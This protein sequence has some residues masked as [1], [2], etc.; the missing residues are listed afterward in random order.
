MVA[1]K[2]WGGRRGARILKWR[3]RYRG[4][5]M[6]GPIREPRVRARVKTCVVRIRWGKG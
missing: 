5:A 3:R 2:V 1:V 4:V 6:E